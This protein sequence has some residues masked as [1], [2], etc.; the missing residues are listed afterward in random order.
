MAP[1]APLS[2]KLLLELNRFRHD[3]S[4]NIAV[5]FVLSTVPTLTTA[6]G[7]VDYIRATAIRSKLQAATDAASVGVS[8][9]QGISEAMNALF[10]KAVADARI[11]S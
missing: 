5:I 9:S 8:M 10:K 7:A 2:R 3:R 6:G 1:V 4:G 11:A